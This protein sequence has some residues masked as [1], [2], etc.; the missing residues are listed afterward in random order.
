M[1]Q[2]TVDILEFLGGFDIT[3]QVIDAKK[4]H[5]GSVLGEP[6]ELVYNV[7]ET[8]WVEQPLATRNSKVSVIRVL[9]W[10]FSEPNILF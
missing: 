2:C 4:L 1:N 3:R 7:P 6:S 8:I 9:V 10:I 5:E